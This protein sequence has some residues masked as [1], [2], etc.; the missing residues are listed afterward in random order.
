MTGQ[1][2]RG[3]TSGFVGKRSEEAELLYH[4]RSKIQAG[5]RRDERHTNHGKSGPSLLSIGS[6]VAKMEY[7]F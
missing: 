2:D 3:E 4:K 6:K 5:E 7:R 1:G